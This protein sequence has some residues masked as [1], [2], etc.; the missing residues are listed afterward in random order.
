MLAEEQGQRD[1][2]QR[3]PQHRRAG[4]QPTPG[5]DETSAGA[6]TSE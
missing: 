6:A 4:T 3:H 1:Q 2:Q 5:H